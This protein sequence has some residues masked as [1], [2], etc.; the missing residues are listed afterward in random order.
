MGKNLIKDTGGG[1]SENLKK[2]LIRF[3]CEVGGTGLGLTISKRILRAHDGDLELMESSSQGTV[4][5]I[6]L[7][8]AK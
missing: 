8:I 4:F 5:K 7:P 2:F 3:F 1:I 6:S